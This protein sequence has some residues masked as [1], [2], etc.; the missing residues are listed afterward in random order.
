MEKEKSIDVSSMYLCEVNRYTINQEFRKLTKKTGN[1]GVMAVVIAMMI[2]VT[3]L[4]CIGI[5]AGT[6]KVE[7]NTSAE[8][9]PITTTESTTTESTRATTPVTKTGKENS[10]SCG[11]YNTI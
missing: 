7:K 8:A 11:V 6:S 4:I 5:G 3:P 9:Y 1:N 2:W 10:K